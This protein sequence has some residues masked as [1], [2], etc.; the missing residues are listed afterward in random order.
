[1]IDI[2]VEPLSP[3][4]VVDEVRTRASGCV[5][6]YVGLI[7]DLSEGKAVAS[8]EYRD[9]AGTARQALQGIADEV[10]QRWQ[11]ENLAIC[12]R[13]GRLEVGEINLVVA[14]ASAHRR[15]GFAACQYIIDRFKQRLPTRKTETYQDGSIK[16]T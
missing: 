7:R 3:E 12:H 8:V 1:M 14:V 6:T 10:R 2:T 16:E 9:P 11:I 15:E 5:V 4:T 13:V